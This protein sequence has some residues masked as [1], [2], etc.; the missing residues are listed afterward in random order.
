M[1]NRWSGFWVG[2]LLAAASLMTSAT[3]P[4]GG[5]GLDEDY[6]KASGSS[7]DAKPTFGPLPGRAVGVL[8]RDVSEAFEAEG[9][10]GPKNTYGFAVGRHSYRMLYVPTG[11]NGDDG[12][13]TVFVA[14][15]EESG[16]RVKFESVELA[17]TDVQ[18]LPDEPYCLV[19]VEVN[20]GLGSPETDRFVATNVEIVERT[21]SM[22]LD[23]MQ[24]V[25]DAR[26]RFAKLVDEKAALLDQRLHKLKQEAIGDDQPTGDPEH[27]VE[28]FV[29][30]LP[31][32]ERLLVR[33][34]R[35]MTAGKYRSGVGTPLKVPRDSKPEPPAQDGSDGVR[36]GTM[37]CV[38]LS[39]E[40]EYDQTGALRKSA[41]S[42]VGTVIRELEPPK[43][44][45]GA[46]PRP[47]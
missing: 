11:D 2:G 5:M 43:A 34:T 15:G 7:E 6:R 12:G 20:N 8:A 16:E 10:S 32:K 28:E 14:V 3:T 45:R 22:R 38:S 27:A 47:R 29:T 46:G 21:R 18:R 1:A 17:T 4:A 40:Y 24:S 31:D 41:A 39:S 25:R 33:L 26:E 30:W 19:Q 42:P 23:V 36:Y 13:E 37:F 44:A 35:R 9:R